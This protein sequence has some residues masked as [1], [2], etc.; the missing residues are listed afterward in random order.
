[1][2]ADTKPAV[3]YPQWLAQL[4]EL[5]RRDELEWLIAGGDR[6][7]LAAYEAGLSPQ[8][9]LQELADM[10]E[11]RGCGCGGGGG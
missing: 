8:E 5:A 4:R 3:A 7:H 1:M 10:A 9:E 6:P 11:W 2:T